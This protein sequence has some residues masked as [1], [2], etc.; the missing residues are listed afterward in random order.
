[1]RR[2]VPVP[3]TKTPRYLLGNAGAADPELSAGDP[4]ELNAL[5]VPE[6]ARY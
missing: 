5:P 3:G 4:A 1:M 2:G 6:G